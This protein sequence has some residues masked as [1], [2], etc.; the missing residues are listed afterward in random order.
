MGKM[1]FIGGKD[2]IRALEWAWDVASKNGS[3]AVIWIH[4]PQPELLSSAESLKQR[5]ERRRSAVR[6]YD[7]QIERGANVIATALPSVALYEQVSMHRNPVE[8][9]ESL[10][11]EL[12]GVTK[13]YFAV[14]QRVDGSDGAAP[15]GA[16]R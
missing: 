3:G 14:R 12:T 15:A 7:L 11:N 5:F 1:Q 9:L 2:N 13:K 10:V 16:E 6:F 8:T 4:G